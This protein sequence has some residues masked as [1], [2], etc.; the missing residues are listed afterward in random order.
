MDEIKE[1]IRI[2][3]NHLSTAMTPAQRNAHVKFL[4]FPKCFDF[5]PDDKFVGAV[6]LWYGLCL[7]VMGADDA[8]VHAAEGSV[9]RRLRAIAVFATDSAE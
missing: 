3:T 1:D 6:R 8:S 5:V 2:V 7:S 9:F 4:M